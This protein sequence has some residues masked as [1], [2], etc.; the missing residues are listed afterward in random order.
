MISGR[1]T[2]APSRSQAWPPLRWNHVGFPNASTVAWILVLNPLLLR[3][4]ASSWS[5]F[6]GAG[7]VLMRTNDGAVIHGVLIVSIAGQMGKRCLQN[8]ALRP[9]AKPPMHILPVAKPFRQVSPGN[10]CAIAIQHGLDKK[11]VI[12]RRSSY[13]FFTSRKQSLDH[14]PL[15]V[16]QR[17][18]SSHSLAP[19]LA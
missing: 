9:P 12:S 6:N 3:P 5:F 2:S 17:I 19:A 14:I 11:P 16:P 18:T 15:I 8:T 10:T 13:R 7:A 1:S 4:I